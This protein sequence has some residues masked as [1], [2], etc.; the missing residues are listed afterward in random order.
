MSLVCRCC[1]TLADGD[2][3]CAYAEADADPAGGNAVGVGAGMT[4]S[5]PG[6]GPSA[7]IVADKG[8][9]CRDPISFVAEGFKCGVGATSGCCEGA[10]AGT[11]AE[12][13]MTPGVAS[14]AGAG[15]AVS[16]VADGIEGGDATGPPLSVRG[17]ATSASAVLESSR[18]AT[19]QKSVELLPG[20]ERL[21]AAARACSTL[22]LTA[23]S[24]CRE[25]R[26]ARSRSRSRPR[27][28]LSSR[29]I[30]HVRWRS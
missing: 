5:R 9:A 11:G 20:S 21:R 19:C 17:F 2:W 13:A 1:M 14:G 15:S 6:K 22:W 8:L 4:R 3:T 27:S 10:G 29:M 12:S 26:A 7:D 16:S 24:R 18:K 25:A 30:S 28:A 23:L